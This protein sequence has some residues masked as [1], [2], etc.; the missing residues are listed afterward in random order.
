MQM[1]LK[2]L[3]IIVTIDIAIEFRYHLDGLLGLGL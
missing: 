1:S 2:Y 3:F